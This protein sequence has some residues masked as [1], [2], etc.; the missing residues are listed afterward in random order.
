L[1]N[2]T[3]WFTTCVNQPQFLKVLGEISLCQNAVPVTPKTNAAA[4]VKAADA[5]PAAGAAANGKQSPHKHLCACIVI[6]WTVLTILSFPLS[7]PPKTEAQLKKEAKKKEKLEKFQ[8]KKE[9]EAK[10]KTQPPA[11]V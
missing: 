10:K 3:R 6:Y 7:G 8:Q 5:S 11:E 4:N 1:T 9:M 2:V